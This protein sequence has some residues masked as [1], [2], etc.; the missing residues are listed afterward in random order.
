LINGKTYVG[1]AS[2]NCMYKR[3][4]SHLLKGIGGSLLLKRAVLKYGL[5]NFAFLVIETTK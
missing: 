3:Y 1:S 4:S 2:I 5:E